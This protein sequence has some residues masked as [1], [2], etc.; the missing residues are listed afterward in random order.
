MGKDVDPDIDVIDMVSQET[1]KYGLL[2]PTI[3]RQKFVQSFHESKNS[4]DVEAMRHTSENPAEDQQKPLDELQQVSGPKSL[5][6]LAVTDKLI[7]Q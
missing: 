3:L 7:S 5:R 6:F 4:Y 2:A 1:L